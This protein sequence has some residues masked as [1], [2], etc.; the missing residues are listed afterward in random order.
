MKN[1]NAA[2]FDLSL[3]GRE[4][5]ERLVLHLMQIDRIR[6]TTLAE[7]ARRLNATAGDAHKVFSDYLAVNSELSARSDA[8]ISRIVGGAGQ[9]QPA[10]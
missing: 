5:L 3:F 9:G 7:L 2:A 10:N 4:T 6:E 8:E 1:D